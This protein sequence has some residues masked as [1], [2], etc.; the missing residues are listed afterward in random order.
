VRSNYHVFKKQENPGVSQQPGNSAAR[1][2]NLHRF[3]QSLCGI[4]SRV[5]RRLRVDRTYVSRVAKGER[6]SPKIE[7]ALLE[8]FDHHTRPDTT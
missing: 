4:Y 7:A 3:V 6:H 2:R 1:L 5:A 8:D